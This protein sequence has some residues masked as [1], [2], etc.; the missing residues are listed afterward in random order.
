MDVITIFLIAIGLS[1]DSFAISITSGLIL[2]K[3][4][5][6]KTLKTA[7]SLAFFQAAMPVI[8]WFLGKGLKQYIESA[9][10]W[11]AFS[12]LLLIGGRMIWE[13]LKKQEDRKI[14]DPTN[15]LV[16]AGLGLATSI[17]ALVI[18]LSFGLLD[19]SL[20]LPILI[21]GVMT[22]VAS[23]LGVYMGCLLVRSTRLRIEILG[24][25][26]LIG[27]GIKILFEHTLM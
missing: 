7:L 11:I 6:Q 26:V 12:L 8:G 13:G 24:G 9:D 23:F 14:F 1:M 10:H 27:I 18:G 25:V 19:V 15:N 4:N 20:L 16:L 2:C 21:I 22:F 17:D 5:F 3:A